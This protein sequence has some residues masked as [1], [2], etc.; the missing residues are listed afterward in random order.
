MMVHANK[1]SGT[2]LVSVLVQLLSFGYS[3]AQQTADMLGR[4]QESLLFKAARVASPQQEVYEVVGLGLPSFTVSNIADGS[5]ESYVHSL[6][7][8]YPLQLGGGRTGFQLIFYGLNDKIQY[9]VAQ[10]GNS[11]SIYMPYALHDN[12]KGKIEQ[13]LSAR[14]KVQLKINLLPSGLR[15]ASWIIH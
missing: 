5:F 1:I 12:L 7:V 15:E 10:E 8:T 2:L 14:R 11:T 3:Q 13:T 9:A 4:Q 6:R